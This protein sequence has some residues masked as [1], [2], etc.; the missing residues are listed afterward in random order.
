MVLVGARTNV[1]ARE[2]RE[3][4]RRKWP[5]GDREPEPLEHLT[6]EVGTGDKLEHSTWKGQFYF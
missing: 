1:A 5:R 2:T 3:R 4:R 6:E